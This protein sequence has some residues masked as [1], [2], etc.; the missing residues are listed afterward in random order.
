MT[1][2]IEVYHCEP[3]NN[4]RK[5]ASVT[6]D[7]GLT[8]IENL[9]RAFELTNNLTPEGWT[10]NKHVKHHPGRP[11]PR[12]TSVGDIMVYGKD[13]FAVDGTGYTHLN[14]K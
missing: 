10:K 13:V 2:P 14:G 8:Y 11:V 5:V 3:F 4:L 1:I 6:E 7:I 9:E 12:S